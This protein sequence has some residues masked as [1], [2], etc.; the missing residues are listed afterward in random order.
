[1]I[2]PIEEL[3]ALGIGIAI[4]D[5]GTGYSGLSRLIAMA[6]ALG[7]HVVAEGIEHP[8]QGALLFELGCDK[9]QGYWF[10]RPCPAD[11]VDLSPREP[12][13]VTSVGMDSAPALRDAG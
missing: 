5:F 4:D 13:Y 8:Y 6:R 11:Q 2:E 10:D 7:L 3:H 12:A 9:G 1:V